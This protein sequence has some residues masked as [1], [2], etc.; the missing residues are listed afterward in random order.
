MTDVD[1]SMEEKLLS[2]EQSAEE[3]K[4]GGKTDYIYHIL[5]TRGEKMACCPCLMPYLQEQISYFHW[6]VLDHLL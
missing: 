5:T 4:D 2:E 1:T 6:D 3:T